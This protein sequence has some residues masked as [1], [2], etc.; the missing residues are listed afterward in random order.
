MRFTLSAVC[1]TRCCN[2]PMRSSFDCCRR[3]SVACNVS[4]CCCI[5]ACFESAC[6]A[7]TEQRS[8]I[9]ATAIDRISFF[10]IEIPGDGLSLYIECSPKA[11]GSTAFCNAAVIV[12]GLA[13]DAELGAAVLLPA[14][15][16]VVGAELLFLSVAH[17]AQPVWTN[18][19]IHQCLLGCVGAILAEAQVVLR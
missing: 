4:S 8:A 15:F 16:R 7:G 12:K 17:C 6:T 9:V 1:S 13:V 11:N 2:T 18:A 3:W 19:R 5:W 14:L 10:R